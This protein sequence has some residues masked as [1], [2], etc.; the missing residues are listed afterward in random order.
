MSGTAVRDAL[1]ALRDALA[2][3]DHDAMALT[4]QLALHDDIETLTCQL[5]TEFHRF[6]ARLQA[7]HTPR[8]LGAKSWNEVLRT[9]WRISGAEAGRRLAEAAALGPR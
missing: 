7:E 5:P 2:A 6:L 1:S 9:R 3:C 8:E 4:E